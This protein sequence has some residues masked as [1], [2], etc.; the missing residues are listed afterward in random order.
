M[1]QTIVITLISIFLLSYGVA[2][3]Q[4]TILEGQAE[5]VVGPPHTPFMIGEL[6][7]DSTGMVV[8]SS[9]VLVPSVPGVSATDGPAAGRQLPPAG[10]TAEGTM[11]PPNAEAVP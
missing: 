5:N 9:G 6:L 7:F 1:A 8:P 4:S 10:A 3:A 2:Y 11:P